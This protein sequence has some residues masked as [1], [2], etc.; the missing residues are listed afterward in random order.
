MRSLSYYLPSVDTVLSYVPSSS[1]FLGKS[2]PSSSDTVDLTK[3]TYDPS[4][5]KHEKHLNDQALT[6]NRYYHAVLSHDA[7]YRAVPVGTTVCLGYSSGIILQ[8]FLLFALMAYIAYY[9]FG[10]KLKDRQELSARFHE[11]LDEID[12]EYEALI[13]QSAEAMK[14]ARSAKAKEIDL[15]KATIVTIKIKHDGL[16]KTVSAIIDDNYVLKFGQKKM[17]WPVELENDKGDKVTQTKTVIVEDENLLDIIRHFSQFATSKELLQ[18]F[19][20]NQLSQSDISPAVLD[21]LASPPH[22]IVFGPDKVKAVKKVE[23]KES[24]ASAS[25]KSN[26][27]LALIKGPSHSIT[28]LASTIGAHARFFAYGR[29]QSTMPELNSIAD[30]AKEK[31]SE[32]IQQKL[33]KVSINLA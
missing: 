31:A 1:Y 19:F 11:K 15:D 28:G 23:K 12:S 3:Q 20:K 22:H 2:V 4:N 6:S 8:A 33:S 10:G 27:E 16:S 13:V 30:A 18:P 26:D 5:E 9:L 25:A 21:I 24:E 14:A 32:L 7:I 29:G 17:E